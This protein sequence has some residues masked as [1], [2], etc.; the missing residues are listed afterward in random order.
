MDYGKFSELCEKHEIVPVYKEITADLLTPVLAYTRVREEG[1]YHFLLESVE[2][3]G[4]LARYSFI[5]KDPYNIIYGYGKEVK[6]SENGEVK[7]FPVNIFDYLQEHIKDK[8]YPVIDDL[9]AFTGG[10]VGYIGYENISLVE[11]VI[12]FTGEDK[13]EV[14]DSIMALYRDL[15]VF[16]HYKHKIVI[17]S[18][19]FVNEHSS[20]KDAYDSALAGIE[21]TKN[22]LLSNTGKIGDFN[23]EEIKTIP[24]NE[25]EEF[26]S[27]VEKAKNHIYEGDIFQIVLSKRFSTQYFGDLLNV[28]RALRMINP[29]PYMYL[30]DFEPEISIIGTSPEDLLSVKDDTAAILPIAGTRKRGR[31]SEEDTLLE[32]D[33]LNDPK[34]IAEHVMLVDLA[35][36]DLGRI[37]DFNSIRLAEE[38]K[39]HRFS[40]VMHIV[41][42]VEGK[43]QKDKDVID[44]FKA[45]FPAGTVSGAPKIK[46]IQLINEFE[47]LKR[48]VY[49]GAIGYIDFRGNMDMCIAIRTLYAKGNRIYWQAGAGIV[50]DS[51]PEYELREIINK[52]KVL[53]NSLQYAGELD[54]SFSN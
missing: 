51:K 32:K 39:I 4:A 5:G 43:L 25:K 36:N 7:T 17:V 29:S 23:T 2:S 8:T 31:T 49:A 40:H 18:N 54:E 19:V 52:S 30:L 34:E 46:A 12:K 3:I 33:L 41:S 1:H 42:R 50:A 44:A 15:I 38:M 45:C 24:D 28:Y 9:P 6:L 35:R 22:Q 11:D 13:M 47:Q 14:P 48:N 20:V 27:V 53:V 16:D 26:Y 37:C 21:K 10:Y